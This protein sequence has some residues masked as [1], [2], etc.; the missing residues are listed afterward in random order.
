MSISVTLCLGTAVAAVPPHVP[1]AWVTD[2]T[3][4]SATLRTVVDPEGAGTTYCFE[5][6][7]EAAYQ[8]NLVAN[9]SGDGYEGAALAPASGSASLG[10]GTQPIKVSQHVGS[11]APLTA[12]RYRPVATSSA[13]T[14]VGPE[15]VLRTQAPTNV[16]VPLDGRAWELVSPADKAGGG[17]GTPESIF[18]GGVFQAAVGGDSFTLSSPSSFGDAAGAPPAS[19]YLS[20]RGGSGWVSATSLRPRNPVATATP[21]TARPS[22]SSPPASRGR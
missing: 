18:G 7:T 17:V 16:S 22:A 21:P 15:H 2:V 8:A 19:Q 6:L 20:S 10:S 9:P 11:L 14:T 5:Y 1:E 3:A 12:Y 4:T 13:G